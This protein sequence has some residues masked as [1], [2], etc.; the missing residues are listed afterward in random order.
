MAE[1]DDDNTSS[2]R[3]RSIGEDFQQK[4]EKFGN[5]ELADYRQRRDLIEKKLHFEYFG[6][7]GKRYQDDLTKGVGWEDHPEIDRSAQT[8]TWPKRP[9]RGQMI[10][11]KIFNIRVWDADEDTDRLGKEWVRDAYD[12]RRE[13]FRT[14]QITAVAKFIAN[15]SETADDCETLKWTYV[16]R[17]LLELGLHPR[18]QRR[19]RSPSHPDAP[20]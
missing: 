11:L 15:Q 5:P 3:K 8:A 20:R 19:R 1:A 4:V 9:I 7:D 13:E 16:K 17:L 14:M 6:Y 10:A 18:V 2:P 12:R